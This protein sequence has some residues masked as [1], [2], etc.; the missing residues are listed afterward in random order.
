MIRYNNLIPILILLLSFQLQAEV[1]L[2]QVLGSNMILQQNKSVPIWG[3][4]SAG[5]LVKVTFGAQT[6]STKADN[7]GK[8]EVVLDPLTAS[9]E[10]AEMI[11]S[12]ENTIRLTNILVGEV[13]LCSGQS[14]MAYSM[15]KSCKYANAKKSQG[16][17]VEA[18]QKV[19][20]PDIRVFLVKRSLYDNDGINRGWEEADFESLKDFSAAGYFFA[21]KLKEELN[22]PIGMISS[23]VS[24]SEIERWAPEEVFSGKEEFKVETPKQPEE[25][26]ELN[27]GKFYYSKIQP[28]APFALKGFLWYQG[29]S[30]CFK[31]ESYEYTDKMRALIDTWRI[32]WRDQELPFYYVQIAPFNYSHGEKET[33][34]TEETLPEFWEAQAAALQIPYT[35]MVVTTDLVDSREDIHPSYKWEVGRRLALWALAKSYGRNNV[36]YSGPMFRSMKVEGNKMVISLSHTGSGLKSSDGQPLNW[37]SVSGAEGDFVPAQAV[38]KGNKIIV[39]ANAVLSP[40]AVRFAWN[41]AAQHN[42]INKEGLP[43]VPFRTDGPTWSSLQ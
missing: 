39:S 28:I 24:G 30:N 42:L 10:P 7:S 37:F 21:K 26:D 12:G 35:G 13:W 33:Q 3:T 32:I 23:A 18:F 11:I 19:D 6:I 1:A 5:E 22:V 14:N 27:A 31:K 41:E 2:P 29:E 16:L 34:L 15:N 43:A 8:W 20:C 36:V 38:I 9:F 25:I 4:A 40:V 17:T